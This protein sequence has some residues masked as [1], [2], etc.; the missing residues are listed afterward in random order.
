MLPITSQSASQAIIRHFFYVYLHLLA[1]YQ[2]LRI[3]PIMSARAMLGQVF[4][5]PHSLCSVYHTA[6]AA[7]ISLPY[8]RVVYAVPAVSQVI[9]FEALLNQLFLFVGMSFRVAVRLMTLFF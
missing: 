8:Q 6:E 9:L 2:H 1:W 7:V 5:E 3:A 4:S